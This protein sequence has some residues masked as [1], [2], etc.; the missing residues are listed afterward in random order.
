MTAWAVADAGS[1]MRVYDLVQ[2]FLLAVA[3]EVIWV[4]ELTDLL[5]LP[6]GVACWQSGNFACKLMQKQPQLRA[7]LDG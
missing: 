7:T 3:C 2:T 1:L 5:V 6:A 4:A